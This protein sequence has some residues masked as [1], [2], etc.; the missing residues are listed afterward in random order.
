MKKYKKTGWLEEMQPRED[1]QSGE[2]ISIPAVYFYYLGN[3]RI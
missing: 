1:K 3:S 2:G